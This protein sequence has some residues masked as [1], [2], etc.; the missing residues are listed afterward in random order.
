MLSLAL[1]LQISMN[2]CQKHNG[3]CTCTVVRELLGNI[4]G[5][6][7]VGFFERKLITSNQEVRVFTPV[8]Q[9]AQPKGLAN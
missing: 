9:N 3:P 7:V 1:L 6:E 2:I 5:D 4:I 8:Y